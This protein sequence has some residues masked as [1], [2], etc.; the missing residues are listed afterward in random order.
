MYEHQKYIV[1]HAA[2]RNDRIRAHD[3]ATDCR[4]ML[5]QFAATGDPTT[6]TLNF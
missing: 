5:E 4:G 6:W 3:Y 2:R 1:I